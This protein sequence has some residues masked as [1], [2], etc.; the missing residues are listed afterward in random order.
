MVRLD[1]DGG[2][3]QARVTTPAYGQLVDESRDPIADL[4]QRARAGVT[5]WHRRSRAEHAV[6]L[7][8]L[9]V[10][11]AVV[12][13]AVRG[14]LVGLVVLVALVAALTV[15]LF[16]RTLRR[17]PLADLAVGYLIGRHRARR[18]TEQYGP[19]YPQQTCYCHPPPPGMPPDGHLSRN[20]CAA[21]GRRAER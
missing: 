1:P 19:G 2:S 15:S 21:H 3:R 16:R 13:P 9:V 7:T 12:S 11:A 18:R 14:A 4:S 5:W 8:G 17:H 10:L 6:V 20:R